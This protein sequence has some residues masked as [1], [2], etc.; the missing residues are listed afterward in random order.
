[1][2]T[3]RRGAALL[4]VI[5]M[6]GILTFLIAEF[7]RR[8]HLEAVLAANT[9]QSLE[10]HAL[11]RSGI[12]AA[13]AM[14]KLDGTQTSNDSRL[15]IWAGPGGDAAIAVPVGDFAIT[16]K[17]ED[18]L[19][20]FPL[21]AIIDLQGKPVPAKV[22]AFEQLLLDL[23]LGDADAA[24]LT[25]ALVDWIDDDDTNDRF[26]YNTKFEVPNAPISHL[27][28]LGRIEGFD[29]LATHEMSKLKAHLDTRREPTINPNT[30]P[31]PVLLA[32]NPSFTQEDAQLLYD[33]L[34][35]NPDT[36]G[37]IANR[38]VP[39]PP[40][41]QMVYS[42]DRFRVTVEG[43]VLG[44]V[45]RAECLVLRDKNTKKIETRDWVEY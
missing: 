26:E 43:N 27:S 31:V 34:S 21:G 30:A 15:D 6:V 45:R 18:A 25:D 3:G 4:L 39:T 16:V 12:A 32:L 1:M 23:K 29:K 10:A 13:I 19:G 44:V 37:A 8:S 42:S 36:N 7:Q 14:L 17:V 20:K 40:T 5:T 2:R 38:Y 41:F 11:A 35:A 33:E 24:S 28:D 9:I 22:E